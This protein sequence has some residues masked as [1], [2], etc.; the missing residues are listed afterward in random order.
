M[1]KLNYLKYLI[2]SLTF[3]FIKSNIN[4]DNNITEIIDKNANNIKQINDSLFLYRKNNILF[5]EVKK[6]LKNISHGNEL[7]EE[8][9]NYMNNIKNNITKDESLY[10]RL[11]PETLFG[12]KE[13]ISCFNLITK[14]AMAKDDTGNFVSTLLIRFIR[15][16]IF[17]I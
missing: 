11:I 15:K 6:I 2:V 1:K 13:N 8:H 3:T 12:Y 7:F 16:Y 4:T 17:K 14:K 9:Y 10:H 5:N